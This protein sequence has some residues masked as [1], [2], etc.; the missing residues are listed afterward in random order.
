M[1]TAPVSRKRDAIR[2]QA[3][4]TVAAACSSIKRAR[5]LGGVDRLG[6]LPDCLLHEILSLLGSRQAARTSALS[7]R[8]RHLWRAVPCL[9]IDQLEFLRSDVVANDAW[10]VNESEWESFE[11]MAD[12][13]LS[14]SA[15]LD[16][17]RLHLV[18]QC[19][20]TTVSRWV[21]RGLR[22]RPAVVEIH[23]NGWK[24]Q[25]PTTSLQLGSDTCRVTKLRLFGVLL[26][27]GFGDNL[28]DQLPVLEDLHI[29]NCRCAIKTIA[30]PTLK[31]LALMVTDSYYI[32]NFFLPVL[33]VPRLASLRLE[34]IYGMHHAYPVT[35]GPENEVLASLVMASICIKDM[36]GQGQLYEEL[37]NNVMDKRKLGSFRS[38]YSFMA[39]LTNAIGSVLLAASPRSCPPPS[40]LEKPHQKF[41]EA[42]GLI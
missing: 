25:W 15:P 41:R 37:E 39:C 38:V 24:I 16:A 10:K 28:G 13:L 34:L 23:D 31:S 8:W 19:R 42:S 36:D 3:T 9:N 11:D 33:A 14:S 4:A 26:M 17:F 5:V 6:D 22:R 29:H 2:T 30:S 35:T 20:S 40:F 7:R 27:P 1:E 32:Y 12:T 21:R 18:D